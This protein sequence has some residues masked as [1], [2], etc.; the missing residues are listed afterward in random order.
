MRVYTDAT[1]RNVVGY[2]KLLLG[3]V[4]LMVLLSQ[5]WK[6]WG[7]DPAIQEIRNLLQSEQTEQ[8]QN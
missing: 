1:F 6:I 2:G 3:L 5:A 7:N 4:V 8:P